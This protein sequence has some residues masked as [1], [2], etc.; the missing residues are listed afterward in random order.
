M[1][2][3]V[4]VPVHDG[5]G[6][7]AECLEA[8]TASV[9]SDVEIVVV[10][11]ASTDDSAEIARRA[12]VRVLGLSR[13]VGAG[14]ARNH[15][16]QRTAGA[17]LVFVDSDVVVAAD[18]V[19][20]LVGTL[21][22]RPD[23]AAVFGSYDA[24]PR[25]PGLVSQWRNLLHHFVHQRGAGEASTFWTGCGAIRRT[26]FEALGGFD[27]G[28]YSHAIEDIELGYRLRAAGHRILLDP[29]I[30]ATHLKR[31]SL[32]SM[33]RTDALLRALPWSRL[34]LARGAPHDHLNVQAQQRTSVALSL[35]AAA[36]LPL[37]LLRPALGL[38][39]LAAVLGVV[40]ANG[41]FVA[42]LARA[43]GLPFAVASVPLLLL[44]YLLSG[45]CYL[46]AWIERALGRSL[47]VP[48]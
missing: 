42:F 41:A 26:T 47:H 36:V 4:I 15:G 20:R 27:E 31:W 35:L 30:Q 13:N 7:L 23:L 11:D 40:V 6:H 22:E 29:A 43:R 48:R 28:P 25:A 17:V 21:E 12:G 24:A 32:A 1:R 19:A 10:D 9:A 38:V 44:H 34:L 46:A 3:S 37:A 16:A 33:L 18:T 2:A 14:A 8:L 5:A 45:L 39:A